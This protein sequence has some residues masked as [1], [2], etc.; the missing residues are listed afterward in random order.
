MRNKTLFFVGAIVLIII[1]AVS[2]LGF[3]LTTKRTKKT[4]PP[5]VIEAPEEE[6][7]SIPLTTE[8]NILPTLPP[9]PTTSSQTTT[10]ISPAPKTGEEVKALF[11][12]ELAFGGLIYPYL[13]VYDPDDGILKYLNL[14]DQ[15]YKE[16]Y[17]F[18]YLK[19]IS[20]SPTRK[21]IV[22]EANGNWRILDLALDQAKELKNLITSLEWLDDKLYYFSNSP[23]PGIYLVDEFTKEP[24]FIKELNLPAV[25]IKIFGKQLLAWLDPFSF[26]K[27]FVFSLNLNNPTSWAIFLDE[28]NYYSLLPSTNGKY[29][30]LSYL[31]ENGSWISKIIDQNKKEIKIFDWASLEEKCTFNDLLV[32]AVPVNSL[33]NLGYW[34]KLK[35]SFRDKIVI[36]NP[37][38]KEEKEIVLGGSFD[39]LKPYLTPLGIIFFNRNDAKLYIV[40]LK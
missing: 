7:Q 17:K 31:D 29:L 22:F 14:E 13:Y 8:E 23:Q 6:R 26:S 1:L 37:S 11:E 33:E 3:Y 9:L 32:C 19:N 2:G 4:E 20:V 39:V 15:T 5:K 27:S 18:S 16:L 36:Y 34:Y 35:R 28:N 40:N 24:K 38:T 12:K 10:E 25:K 21:R 30:Y